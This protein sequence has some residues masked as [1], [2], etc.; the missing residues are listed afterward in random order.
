MAQQSTAASPP[1]RF[2]VGRIAW[3]FFVLV[4]FG[5]LLFLLVSEFM[6]DSPTPAELH[7]L[8]I[9]QD[10]P[11]PDALP[12]PHRRSQNPF[13]AGQA[14]RFDHFLFPG[15]N[16]LP[17]NSSSSIPGLTRIKRQPS[18]ITPILMQELMGTLLS[19]IPR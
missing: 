8:Q 11:L 16:P 2:S 12:D 1:Q 6:R 15:V 14:Q 18:N 3:W 10:I 5:L 17:T 13:A 9:V 4:S 19:S 7:R